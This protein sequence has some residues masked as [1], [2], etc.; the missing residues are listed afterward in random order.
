MNVEDRLASII[1]KMCWDKAKF[2]STRY[3]I[4]PFPVALNSHKFTLRRT[5]LRDPIKSSQHSRNSAAFRRGNARNT[6]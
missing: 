3:L 1:C 6:N 5:A 2:L 4:V